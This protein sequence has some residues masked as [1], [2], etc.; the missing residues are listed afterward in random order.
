M[1]DSPRVMITN[2]GEHPA[3]AWAELSS[4]EIISIDPTS[5]STNAQIGRMLELKIMM[6]LEEYYTHVIEAEHAQL[7]A[8][9]DGRLESP[10]DGG[11]HDPEEV[12]LK[13]QELTKGTPFEAH[14]L[15]ENAVN[16]ITNVLAHH[17]AL[18]M[19]VARSTYADS[20]G[21]AKAEAWKEARAELGIGA[22][23]EGAASVTIQ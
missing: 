14:F 2:G 21:T 9:G 23:H 11:E 15:S 8:D 7:D 16:N 19:D 10:L 20:A 17:S 1:V 13:I 4:N 3:S 6:A 18:A 12:I 5:Q 22:A